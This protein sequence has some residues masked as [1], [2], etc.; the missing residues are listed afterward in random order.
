MAGLRFTRTAGQTSTPLETRSG[1]YIYNGDPA[2][3]HDWEFRTL[4]RLKLYEDAIKAKAQKKASRRNSRRS[5]TPQDEPTDA[6]AEVDAPGELP[7]GGDLAS[8]AAAM[9][10]ESPS[11]TSRSSKH[12]KSSKPSVTSRASHGPKDLPEGDDLDELSASA[13]QAR[14]EMVQKVLEGLREE[15]FELARDIGVDVLTQPVG[16]GSLLRNS[17]I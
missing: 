9:S 12:G 6:D 7:N 8:L 10:R 16:Y 3:F 1:S 4:M 2:Y 15:A 17:V 14:T 13:T 5:P 11:D